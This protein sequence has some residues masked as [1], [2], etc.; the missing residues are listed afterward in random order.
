MSLHNATV[1]STLLRCPQPAPDCAVEALLASIFFE[2]RISSWMQGLRAR[3]QGLG[4]RITGF[5]AQKMLVFPVSL[6]TAM[7][8]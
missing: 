7:S 5:G 2:F 6:G 4:F 8:S 3:V 1:G